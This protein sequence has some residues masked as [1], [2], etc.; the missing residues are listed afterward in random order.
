MSQGWDCDAYKFVIA[1]RAL[2]FLMKLIVFLLKEPVK[3]EKNMCDKLSQK[4]N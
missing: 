2:D 3:I 4:V 1:T